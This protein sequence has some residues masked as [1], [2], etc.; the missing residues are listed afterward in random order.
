MAAAVDSTGA[1][2][3][4]AA[5][6]TTAAEDATEAEDTTAAQD[7]AAPAPTAAAIEPAELTVEAGE[8]RPVHDICD[9]EIPE[10]RAL[11]SDPSDHPEAKKSE[12]D[13]VTLESNP[14]E[15]TTSQTDT[16]EI[17]EN[18][19]T[20]YIYMDH[21][22]IKFSSCSTIFL[23]DTTASCP[24]FKMTLKSVALEIYYLIKKRDGN[25]TMEI[26]DERI[27]PFNRGEVLE[28]HFMCDPT[29]KAIYRFIRTMFCVKR[30][31]ADLAII[32]LVYIKR[33]V[34]CADINICPTNWRRIVLGA[35]LLVIKAGS[36]VAVDNKD[37]CGLFEKITVDDMN[38]L[39]RWYLELINYNLNV[40]LSVYTR[41]YFCLRA[42]AFRHGLGLPYYLLD[43]ER[44]WDLK[45]LS[46]IDQEEVF[47]TARKTGALSADDLICL[48]RAKA[49]L[50]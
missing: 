5:E 24:H 40:S 6:D 18:S 47:Y 27:F 38:E 12:V 1:E 45:A 23:E 20:N 33:L 30:L 48:Q 31:D 50:S 14:S 29:H 10:D 13:D 36:S 25:R 15:A 43:R 34:K 4:A 49:V 46:R 28:E 2:N 37:L 44:A 35:I 21:F 9:G 41:C 3:T 32:S 22:S 16:Q 7:T 42:L 26:L 17:G 11:E 39:Q 19:S 8:D